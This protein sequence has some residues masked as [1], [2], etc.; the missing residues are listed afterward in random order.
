V[1]SEHLAYSALRSI[2]A[3]PPHDERL[4]RSHIEYRPHS[5]AAQRVRVAHFGDAVNSSL[6]TPQS[7]DPTG[8]GRPPEVAFDLPAHLDVGFLEEAR[9]VRDAGDEER[10]HALDGPGSRSSAVIALSFLR[11]RD[12]QSRRDSLRRRKNLAGGNAGL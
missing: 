11:R 9:I 2:E 8:A 10:G 7:Q 5:A 1:A 12:L 6:A 4:A 3:L